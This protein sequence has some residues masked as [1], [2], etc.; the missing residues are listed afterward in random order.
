MGFCAPLSNVMYNTVHSQCS[1]SSMSKGYV[2]DSLL[3]LPVTSYELACIVYVM[4]IYMFVLVIIVCICSRFVS[5]CNKDCLVAIT[6]G[7][8]LCLLNVQ[9]AEDACQAMLNIFTV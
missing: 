3:R 2:Y 1:H 5:Y 7:L 8:C 4:G 6:I 9:K